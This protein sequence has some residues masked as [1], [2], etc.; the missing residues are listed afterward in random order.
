MKALLINPPWYRFFGHSYTQ[1]P[2]GL[3][4]IAGMLHEN[5]VKTKIYN[6]D[7]ALESEKTSALNITKNYGNYQKALEAENHPIWLEIEET[8]REQGP[9]IIGISS[10]TAKHKSAEKV[11]AL[12]KGIDRYITVVMGGP[13][14]T[15]MP[16]ETMR[17]ENTDIAVIGEGEMTFLELAGLLEE[18]ESLD[19]CKG[20]AYKR[21][22]KIRR[23]G[24]REPIQDLDLLPMPAKNL[25]IGK[26]KYPPGS[27]SDMITSRGC[28][29]RCVYCNS[30]QIWGNKVRYRSPENIIKEIRLAKKEHGIKRVDFK[31][32]TFTSD[33]GRVEAICQEIEK[34]GKLKW[35]CIT[36]ADRMN[37]GM[38]E[39]MKKSGC[40]S[41]S[42]ALESASDSTL[43]KL[44]KGFK[45][46]DV[47][48]AGR[49]LREQKI[50]YN[51]YIMAGFPWETE[52]DM[53]ETIELAKKME[54]GS[55]V[56]SITTP[57]PGTELARMYRQKGLGNISHQS[58][59]NPPPDGM[60]KERFKRLL[61]ELESEVEEYN[62][63]T[64]I[65]EKIRKNSLVKKIREIGI[66]REMIT[67]MK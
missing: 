51:L 37:E 27:F 24:Q 26:N 56:F 29:Y 13:H 39:K 18:V 12:A 16:E 8:I 61:I 5:G 23:T 35:S 20:I 10:M 53:R 19:K 9:D 34:E 22:G 55:I 67:K 15:V 62:N 48:R 11:A 58:P 14:P 41:V 38:L 66:V 7:F 43:Q 2:L 30:P 65:K 36:R 54:P 3:A 52:K 49:M 40:C 42:I 31:D 1:V 21:R 33:P 46:Q 28:G 47:E 59:E 17:D 6:S 4:Y 64:T 32:D 44:R 63:R 50:P 25:L 45:V 60:G 57:S